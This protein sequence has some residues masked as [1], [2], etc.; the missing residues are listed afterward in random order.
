MK[1]IADYLDKKLITFLNVKNREE[2]IKQMVD[3]FDQNKKLSSKKEFYEAILHREKI[4]STGIG[5][6]VAIP[7][8]KLSSFKDFHI[9][10]GIIKEKG[11]DWDA[12]DKAP[13]NIIFMIAGPDNQQTEYLQVLSLLTMIIKNEKTRK[14]LVSAATS[15]DVIK[16]LSKF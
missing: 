12:I 2:V 15:E 7:H 4:V 14:Q 10:I 11:I 8:A 9:A 5:M 3:L 1:S 13:V 16:I 6:G